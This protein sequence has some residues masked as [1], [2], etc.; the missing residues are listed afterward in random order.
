MRT[1]DA[2]GEAMGGDASFEMSTSKMK[3]GSAA[4][5]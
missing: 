2:E 5:A 3:V 4:Q 1:V